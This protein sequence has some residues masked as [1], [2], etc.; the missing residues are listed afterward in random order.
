MTILDRRTDT[1]LL[2]LRLAVATIFIAHGCQKLF[3]MGHEGV[4][5]FFTQLG[6]P[7]P[8]INAWFISILEFGGGLML[9]A[10]IY[11]RI[12]G[13]LF[14][15]DMVVAIAVALFPRGFYQGY[16]LEFLLAAASL[17]LALAGGGSLSL[18]IRLAARKA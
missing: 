13:L 8:G 6:I 4:T 17:A 10:G 11:T 2:V 1:A 12:L 14:L 18:D 16:Q 5:G 9:M 7:M 3:V 15:G